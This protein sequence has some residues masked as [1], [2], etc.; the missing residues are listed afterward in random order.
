MKKRSFSLPVIFLCSLLIASVSHAGK[1]KIYRVPKG[2]V[3]KLVIYE[4]PTVHSRAIKK[5]PANTRWIVR[6]PGIKT[7]SS[8][9]TWLKVSCDGKEGWMPKRLLVF[10]ARATSIAAKNPKCLM[11]KTRTKACDSSI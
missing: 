3:A 1:Y 10:D 8:K 11:N 9:N 4:N 5:L 6:L 7:Y 2:K